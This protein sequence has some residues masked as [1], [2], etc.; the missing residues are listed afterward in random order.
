MAVKPAVVVEIGTLAVEG[1][2]AP[3][4]AVVRAFGAELERL[5][6]A[7][8]AAGVFAADGTRPSAHVTTRPIAT[9]SAGTAGVAIARAVFRGL[10]R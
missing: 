7:P 8:G 6:A 9:A 3:G 10:S 4:E 5:L 1:I 2:A